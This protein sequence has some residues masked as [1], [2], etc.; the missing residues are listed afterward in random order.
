MTNRF[1][2]LLKWMDNLQRNTYLSSREYLQAVRY[3]ILICYSDS[4]CKL[5]FLT[6]LIHFQQIGQ[7]WS[8]KYLISS[9]FCIDLLFAFFTL[10]F[11]SQI[12]EYILY[13]FSLRNFLNR[14]MM[15]VAIKNVTYLPLLINFVTTKIKRMYAK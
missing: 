4:N 9:Y 14:K 2:K 6:I 13:F 15:T 7:V 11:T 3:I 10:S 12:N 5:I 1:L 8:G